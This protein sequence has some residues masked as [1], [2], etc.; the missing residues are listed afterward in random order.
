MK[1]EV[2]MTALTTEEEN[3]YFSEGVDSLS[4]GNEF[5]DPRWNFQRRGR[6]RKR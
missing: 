3:Q 6:E 2:F 4:V 1:L 5:F